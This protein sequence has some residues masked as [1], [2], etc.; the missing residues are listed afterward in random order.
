MKTIQVIS[1]GAII[2]IIFTI[3]F[4]KSPKASGV[5]GGKQASDI[6]T[7]AGGTLSAIILAL[8]G[9]KK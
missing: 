9:E 4:V 8:Q 5:S 1:W 6:I 2:A 3:L 7:S